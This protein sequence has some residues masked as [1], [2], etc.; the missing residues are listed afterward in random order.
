MR[1]DPPVLAPQQAGTATQTD[2][3]P[4]WRCHRQRVARGVFT[5]G[6]CVPPRVASGHPVSCDTP[7]GPPCLPATQAAP[8]LGWQCCDPTLGTKR[9]VF[10]APLVPTGHCWGATS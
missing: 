3:G 7:S 5:K 1:A 6:V 2:T 10:V 9:Q 4:P 8:S